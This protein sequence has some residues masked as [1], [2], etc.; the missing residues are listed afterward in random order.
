MT[1]TLP[2]FFIPENL[3][4]EKLLQA[5]NVEIESCGEDVE[6]FDVFMTIRDGLKCHT[7]HKPD[8]TRFLRSIKSRIQVDALDD[9]NIACFISACQYYYGF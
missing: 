1:T 4:V 8:F 3:L 2:T 5:F 7:I 6:N 9:E